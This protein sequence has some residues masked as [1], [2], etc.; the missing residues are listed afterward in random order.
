MT[1]HRSIDRNADVHALLRVLAHLLE[2]AHG[3]LMLAWG[4]GLP[5]LVWRGWPRLRHAY[6]LFSLGF[7][8]VSLASHLLLGQCA[9]TLWSHLLW[10]AA[11]ETRERVPFVITF[12]NRVAHIRPSEDTAVLIW[13]IAIAT[14]CM[15]ALWAW[16]FRGRPSRYGS[17]EHGRIQ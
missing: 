3:L 16:R 13:E 12:T 14:Y 9:L 7:V 15:L 1:H 11:G 8:L 6:I 2:L 17:R 10:E 5:L 4:I